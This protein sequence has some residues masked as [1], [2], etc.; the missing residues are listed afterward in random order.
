MTCE[1]INGDLTLAR[2]NEGETEFVAM[3]MV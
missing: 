1:A 2:P 3:P